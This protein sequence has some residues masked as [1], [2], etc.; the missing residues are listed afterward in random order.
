MLKTFTNYVARYNMTTNNNWTKIS[1]LVKT[2]HITG[3]NNEKNQLSGSVLLAD[4]RNGENLSKWEPE[5]CIKMLQL[6][7]VDNYL[8][9]KKLIQ[10]ADT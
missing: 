2:K 3:A 9:I 7:G 1:N 6:P 5:L 4:M 10:K 8:G